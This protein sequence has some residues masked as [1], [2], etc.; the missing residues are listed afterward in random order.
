MKCG[1]PLALKMGTMHCTGSP[2]HA[3]LGSLSAWELYD[4]KGPYRAP[5][6]I[7]TEHQHARVETVHEI[8]QNVRLELDI[9]V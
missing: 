7:T 4:K 8:S 5:G 1:V 6:A 3:Y 2:L 9:R